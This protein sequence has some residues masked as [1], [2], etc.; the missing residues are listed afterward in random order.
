MNRKKLYVNVINQQDGEKVIAC[1]SPCEETDILSD[2]N[3]WSCNWQRFWNKADWD[4]ECI[5]K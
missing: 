2:A 4:C 1:L 5:V 3:D